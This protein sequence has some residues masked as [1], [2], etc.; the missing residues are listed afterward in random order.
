[1]G[2]PNRQSEPSGKLFGQLITRK[3]W[4]KV[5]RMLA[6]GQW[7]PALRGIIRKLKQPES[8]MEASYTYAMIKER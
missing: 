1:M 4:N 5:K 7:Q 8:L 6:Q 3:N 2:M